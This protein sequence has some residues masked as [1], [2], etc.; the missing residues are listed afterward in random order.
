MSDELVEAVAR[1]MCEDGGF[2]PDERMANGGPRWGYYVPG[3]VAAIR[4][5]APMMAERFERIARANQYSPAPYCDT[6]KSIRQLTKEM[7]DG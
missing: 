4:T 1:A 3:A 6:L 7:A 5:L 2:D